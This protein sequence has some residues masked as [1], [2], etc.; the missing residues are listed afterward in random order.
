MRRPIASALLAPLLAAP[1]LV[2]LGAAAARAGPAPITCDTGQMSQPGR[3]Q[4][5][6][7]DRLHFVKDGDGCPDDTAPC[8]ARSLRHARR[9]AADRHR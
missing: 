6:G 4:V 2:G 9:R 7:A 1:L 8:Q 5:I 3:A